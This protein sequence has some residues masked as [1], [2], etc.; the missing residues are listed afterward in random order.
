MWVLSN[1]LVDLGVN[2]MPLSKSPVGIVAMDELDFDQFVL[3]SLQELDRKQKSLTKNYRLGK[4]AAYAFD[5]TT[6]RLQFQDE[7]GEVRVQAET[8]QLGSFSAKS[9]TWQWAWANKS[10]PSA[11]RKTSEILKELYELTGMDAFKTPTID[12]DEDL[13]S[14]LVAMCVRHLDALGCY[15]MSDGSTGQ[16]RVFV[17]IREIAKTKK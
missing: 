14:E 8:W 3:Q 16:L 11:V 5:A 1:V 17:A 7:S 4:W 9:K 6:S 10:T 12:V 13:V 2:L 15:A